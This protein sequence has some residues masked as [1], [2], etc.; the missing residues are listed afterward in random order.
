[1]GRNIAKCIATEI[2]VSCNVGRFAKVRVFIVLISNISFFFFFHFFI[3]SFIFW[4]ICV[5][6]RW[7]WWLRKC[8]KN[9]KKKWDFFFLSNN[10]QFAL[11]VRVISQFF[12]SF[13]SVTDSMR[14]VL[15]L[16]LGWHVWK[17]VP[18]KWDKLQRQLMYWKRNKKNRR[19]ARRMPNGCRWSGWVQVDAILQLVLFE[20]SI[21]EMKFFVF[22][23]VVENLSICYKLESMRNKRVLQLHVSLTY[24]KILQDKRNLHNY[25]RSIFFFAV[26]TNHWKM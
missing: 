3:F 22:G 19:Y 5:N 8:W 17:I 15:K 26:V 6:G 4:I 13:Y 14:N 2:T 12:F 10:C 1:M 16:K 9:K 23:I 24:W 20:F 25:F 11:Q 21:I 18:S 7:W